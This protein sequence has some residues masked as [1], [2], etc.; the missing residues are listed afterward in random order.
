MTSACLRAALILAVLAILGWAGASAPALGIQ[1]DA[2]HDP[3]AVPSDR[4]TSTTG[5]ALN[6]KAASLLDD[7]VEV[8]DEQEDDQPD[9]DGIAIPHKPSSPKPITFVSPQSFLLSVPSSG[10]PSVPDVLSKPQRDQ[11][12]RYCRLLI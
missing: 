9:E 12:L 6:S 4:L 1:V 7:E 8:P 2:S 11:F 5:P 10:L 3:A